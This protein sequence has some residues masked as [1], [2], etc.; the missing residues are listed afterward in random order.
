M[1]ELLVYGAIN[2]FSSAAFI[3][4]FSGIDPESELTVRVNTDGGSPE[5]M[6][7]M[8][9]KFS[10]HPGKKRVKLDGKAH[11]GG[12]FFPLYADEV[13]ALD[14]TESLLHRAAYPDWFEKSEYFTEPLRQNLERINTSLRK[15]FEAKVDVKVF[16]EMKGVKVKDIFSMD[17]RIDVF[18][19][20]KELKKLGIVNKIVQL[21]PKRRTMINTEM[22]RIAAQYSGQ[23]VEE[24]KQESKPETDANKHTMNA[25]EL[26]EKH[27]E[28]YNEVFNAG[29]AAERDR[30]EACLVFIDIDAK[31]VKEAIESGN[32]LSQKQTAEFSLKAM[33][34]QKLAELEKES[35]D[36]VTT[37][38][39]KT[40]KTEAEAKVD[41]F[42]AEVDSILKINKKT[43]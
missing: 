18:L 7:G 15:A 23:E 37:E 35:P 36:A 33:N 12:L 34:A 10:E 43:A 4:S 17:D 42:E 1:N 2:S 19:S 3:E 16:E 28:V 24:I 8:A 27:P 40:E 26:K 41:A 30:V 13:E 32:P 21:T 9:A 25:S 6:W 38:E 31:G 5:Y 29:I 22:A 39:A 14:V 11:S 20:A